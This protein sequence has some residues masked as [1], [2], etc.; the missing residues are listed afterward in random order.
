MF[1]MKLIEILES[2]VIMEYSEGVVKK[3]VVKFK[4]EMEIISPSM[5][6]LNKKIEFFYT[7]Y[8]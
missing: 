5:A 7:P 1:D 8:L 3:L 6:K 2:I 4:N